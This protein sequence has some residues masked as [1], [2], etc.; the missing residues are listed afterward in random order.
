MSHFLG[1]QCLEVTLLFSNLYY[2]GPLTGV[3]THEGDKLFFWCSEELMFKYA[4]TDPT[5]IASGDEEDLHQFHRCRIFN[6]YKLP[7]EL[8]DDIISNNAL[9]EVMKKDQ[10]KFNNYSEISKKLPDYFKSWDEF[11]KVAWKWLVGYTTEDVWN[12]KE[13]GTKRYA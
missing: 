6:L 5:I 9:W 7:Q 11:S 1:F 8:M 3:C 13:W 10:S 4:E 12:T 2:D